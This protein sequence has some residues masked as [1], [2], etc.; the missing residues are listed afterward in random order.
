MIVV[1]TPELD[2]AK[3]LFPFLQTLDEEELRGGGIVKATLPKGAAA[4]VEGEPCRHVAFVL[5]G[6]IRVYKTS[7]DGRQLTLYYVTAGDSCVLMWASVLADARYNA[8]AMVSSDADVLLV[9]VPVFHRWMQRYEAV[10]RFVYASFAHRLA[11]VMML[12]DEVLFRHVDQ[13]LAT[14]L[15]QR[16]TPEEPILYMTHEQLALELGTAREVVSRILKSFEEDGAVQ[17]LR[18]RVEVTDRRVLARKRDGAA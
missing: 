7:E 11:A 1:L 18:G 9:P 6:S 5:S 10:R 2:D 16:T 14:L 15:L 3:K 8:Q 17:L 13:R 12:V 4:F